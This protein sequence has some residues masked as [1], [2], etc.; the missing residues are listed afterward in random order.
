MDPVIVTC[1]A[2][3]RHYRIPAFG[4]VLAAGQNAITDPKL[5]LFLLRFPSKAAAINPQECIDKGYLQPED[6]A[7][8]GY[9]VK[10]AGPVELDQKIEIPE[11]I[12][13][14]AK[15]TKQ[16]LLDWC[17]DDRHQVKYKSTW[18]KEQFVRACQKAAKKMREE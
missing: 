7:R 10:G 9:D 6:V 16:E 14:F 18:S 5:M 17:D 12:P 4:V 8:L 15:M 13:D 11:A 1:P 3:M 2:S